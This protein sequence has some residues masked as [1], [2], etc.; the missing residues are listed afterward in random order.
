MTQ[1]R[2][3]IAFGVR[4]VSPALHF[5]TLPFRPPDRI[6]PTPSRSPRFTFLRPSLRFSV[7]PAMDAPVA[8]T[9]GANSG[10]GLAVSVALARA[11]HV[12]YAAMRDAASPEEL[13]AAVASAPLPAAAAV[14]VLRMDVGNDDSV[15]LAVASVLAATGDRVDVAVASAGYGVVMNVEDAT[16]ED[17][18]SCMNVNFYGA[19]R[20]VKAVVP[21][22]RRRRAGR[23]FGV[24]SI[25]GLVGIPFFGPYSASKFAMEGF[26]ECC[27]AEYKPLG[28]HFILVRWAVARSVSHRSCSFL[29]AC[30]ALPVRRSCMPAHL[31]LV[32]SSQSHSRARHLLTALFYLSF[33]TYFLGG[34]SQVE[35]GPVATNVGSRAKVNRSPPGDLAPICT[36]AQAKTTSMMVGSMQSADDCAAYFLRAVANPVPALRYM[37]HEASAKTILCKYVDLDGAG[38][39][40]ATAAMTELEPEGGAHQSQE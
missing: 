8:I 17:V 36:A 37:T 14:H 16:V 23:I 34:S 3:Y 31:L 27:A 26:W 13:L 12:V 7:A 38:V 21:A 28:V 40:A 30:F 33:H 19:V 35:P 2:C 20:L 4:A 6:L 11:G 5:F 22:M 32:A 29:A 10:I 39:A 24:S 18:S 9:T 15:A 25:A 1:G